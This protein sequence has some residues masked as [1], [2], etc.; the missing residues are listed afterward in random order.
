MADGAFGGPGGGLSCAAARAAKAKTSAPDARLDPE[1]ARDDL[2]VLLTRAGQ[3]D[4]RAAV[5]D[6]DVGHDSNFTHGDSRFLPD[7]A[8][9]AS[10]C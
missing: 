7:H 5:L 2:Q 4:E 6:L 8:K 10:H 9:R 1:G 3:R